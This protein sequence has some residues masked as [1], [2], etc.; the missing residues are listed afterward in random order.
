MLLL[1]LCATWEANSNRIFKEKRYVTLKKANFTMAEV[2]F[3]PLTMDNREI[4]L[5]LHNFDMPLTGEGNFSSETT[6]MDNC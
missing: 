1:L 3:L 6:P 2:Q 5:H 4:H